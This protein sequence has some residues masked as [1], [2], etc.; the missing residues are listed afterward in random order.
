[1][2]VQASN[3]LYPTYD[4]NGRVSY[5]LLPTKKFIPLP[6]ES[7][8]PL[9]SAFR[10]ASPATRIDQ[11][12]A[13]VPTLKESLSVAA[14]NQFAMTLDTYDPR[15]RAK[16]DQPFG[17]DN[18]SQCFR[19]EP[20]LRHV[21]LPLWKS[22]FLYNCHDVWIALA[23]A[24][25]EAAVF[26]ALLDEYGD[27]QFGSLQG[28]PLDW[29]DETEVNR[30]RVRM[31]TAALMHFNGSAADLVRW[32]G[33]PHVAAHRDHPTI[34]RRLKLAGVPH[35]TYED[36]KRIFYHGVPRLCNASA[37]EANFQAFFQ[38]R[39]HA[40]VDEDPMK[41]YKALVKDNKRG[42]TLLFDERFIPF[43][44]HCHVTPQGIV[45]LDTINKNPRPIF[46]SSFRPFPWCSAINDWTH[47]SNEPPLTFAE[48]ELNFMIWLYNLRISYPLEE[49]YLADD[50]V[51][52]AF[53][54]S[55]YPPNLVALHTSRQC[56]LGV[57][58]TGATFG[59]NTSPSNF[60]PLADGRRYLAQYL[61]LNDHSVVKRTVSVLPPI[62]LADSPSDDVIASFTK[63]DTDSL[64]LGVFYPNGDRRPPPFPMHVDDLFNADVALYMERSITAS[65]A[66]LFDVLGWPDSR[67]PL[68]L[69]LDKF[70]ASYTHLQRM[71]GQ[72]FDSRRLTV[73]MLAYK[74]EAL[75]S[76]LQLWQSTTE[77]SLHDIAQL[78]GVL[79]FHTRYARWARC[80][81]FALQNAVCRALH[82]RFYALQRQYNRFAAREQAVCESLPT[83]LL[84]R[85]SSIVAKE[86]A[87]FLWNKRATFATTP[88]VTACICFLL[89]YVQTHDNPWETPLGM[90]IPR[91]PHFSSYGDASFVGCGGVNPK[92]QF[93]FDVPWSP[94]L[95]KALKLKSSDDGF[96]HINDMEFIT[97]IL[98]LAAISVRLHQ[99]PPSIDQSVFPHGRPDIPVWLGYTDNMVSRSWEAKATACS[100]RG[101][102]LIGVYSAL[103]QQTRLHT[104]SRH[105]K[106]ELNVV[107][108][109]ISRNNFALP[110]PQRFSQ[111]FVKHPSLATFDY[112]LPSPALLHLLS[113]RLFSEHRLLPCDLPKPLGH[114]EAAGCT[115]FISPSL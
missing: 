39:N 110:L 100:G 56:G 62:H 17:K 6:F 37:T 53:R 25:P 26:L 90:I 94:T 11:K 15:I 49:I 80:W 43:V 82:K 65:V 67:V 73:G 31:T 102:A 46:D 115:T 113:S 83:S 54:H 19:A 70:E 88:D 98:M 14:L 34:L 55:K 40:T 7:N 9:P 104:V 12:P 5:H 22:G 76:L 108:D 35:D 99:L 96:V 72:A 4:V 21:F 68:P 75:I 106:G 57:F 10:P 86:K 44:L 109:D 63:A 85:L 87:V 93:W 112:F 69:S 89:Q 66:A 78:I 105:V 97:L 41:T 84:D 33:G 30:D 77:Y 107:A 74:R 32:I 81:Y 51:S 95:R 13:P 23:A 71:V 42:Y 1:M 60:Q 24:S 18:V 45:D 29:N 38:Y 114:F 91:I 3:Q 92:L 58:N 8:Y 111:L 79:E 61:W 59:D 64:N 50:D 16:L 36:I 47:K 48:A 28:F 103:L 52:G 27:V 2:D 20:R 101:Q